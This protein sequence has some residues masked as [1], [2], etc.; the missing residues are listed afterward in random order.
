MKTKAFNVYQIIPS[1][2]T[3]GLHKFIL[4]STLNT[5]AAAKE[6]IQSNQQQGVYTITKIY[7]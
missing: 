5:K 4:K 3:S 7:F 1:D 2:E 6:F